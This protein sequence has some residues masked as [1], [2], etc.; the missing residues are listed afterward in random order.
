MIRVFLPSQVD[1]YTAGER[2]QHFDAQGIR[3]LSDVM[4]ALDRRF[5]GIR[6]RLVDEQGGIR[7]HIAMFVGETMVRSLEVPV[8]DNNRVQ[9]VGALS[10]G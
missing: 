5:P 8:A 6:F 7:R 1:S 2:E 4:V 3:S 9:I 10:G